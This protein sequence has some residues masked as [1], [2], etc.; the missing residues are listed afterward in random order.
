[1][2]VPHILL[3]IS[4]DSC[5]LRFKDFAKES[6]RQCSR[7]KSKNQIHDKA[8]EMPQTILNLQD[9]KQRESSSRKLSNFL[10]E[11]RNSKH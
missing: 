9:E 5:L 8:P 10:L 1:M 6:H 7:K 3:F 4:F 11:V 2:W